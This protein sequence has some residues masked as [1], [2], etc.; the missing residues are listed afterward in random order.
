LFVC[1]ECETSIPSQCG[2]GCMKRPSLTPDACE[3]SGGR[4]V[5]DIGDGAVH[6]PEY[7]CPSGA[8]QSGTIVTSDGLSIGIEGAV[9]CP[10]VPLPY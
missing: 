7:R 5:G 9:C 4:V 3:A 1:N 2:C 10:I 6:R 8:P